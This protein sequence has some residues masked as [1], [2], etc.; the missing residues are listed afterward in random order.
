M[1]KKKQSDR[2]T[3][4]QVT[5]R[6]P[7]CG[8]DPFWREYGGFRVAAFDTEQFVVRDLFS[9]DYVFKF[10]LY[11][12]PYRWG[13]QHAEALLNDIMEAAGT[14]GSRVGS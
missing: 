6:G 1:T 4:V 8:M 14:V 5:G 9:D 13:T 11:Q 10:P 3:V 2:W 12:R 7:W